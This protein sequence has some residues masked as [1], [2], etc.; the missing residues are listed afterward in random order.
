MRSGVTF[1]LAVMLI[2]WA[3]WITWEILHPMIEKETTPPED[4]EAKQDDLDSPIG[5]HAGSAE[6]PK[7]TA[8]NLTREVSR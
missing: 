4:G 1:V 3:I 6:T 8:D 2:A 5:G 7:A